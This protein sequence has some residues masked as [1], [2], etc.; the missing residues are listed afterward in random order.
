MIQVLLSGVLSSVIAAMVI[1]GFKL[2]SK[3]FAG[4]YKKLEENISRLELKIDYMEIKHEALILA[5]HNY[6]HNGFYINYKKEL[7][8]LANDYKFVSKAGE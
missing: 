8:R 2:L 6:F 5:L 1:A 3:T 4:H 7:E